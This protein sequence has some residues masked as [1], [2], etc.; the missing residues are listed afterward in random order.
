MAPEEVELFVA[1]KLSL[2]QLDDSATKVESAPTTIKFPKDFIGIFS[3]TT[4]LNL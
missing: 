4:R 1:T 3:K 2:S